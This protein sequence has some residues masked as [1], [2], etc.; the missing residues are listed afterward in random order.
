MDVRNERG[1]GIAGIQN[2][3]IIEVGECSAH[4]KW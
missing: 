3:Y 1:N 2:T 4:R